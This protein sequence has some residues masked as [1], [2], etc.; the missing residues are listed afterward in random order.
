MEGLEVDFKGI[1]LVE[2]Y[3]QPRDSAGQE[4]EREKQAWTRRLL[5]REA[6]VCAP[7]VC[8]EIRR[9]CRESVV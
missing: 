4:K 5:A 9:E 1:Q 3:D 2:D 7:V 8:S 6:D